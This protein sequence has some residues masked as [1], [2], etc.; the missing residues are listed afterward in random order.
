[1]SKD[2]WS[3]DWDNLPL[4]KGTNADDLRITQ[5]GAELTRLSDYTKKSEEE[6][7]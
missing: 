5:E 1:M 6:S 4:E 2:N 3:N 7:E